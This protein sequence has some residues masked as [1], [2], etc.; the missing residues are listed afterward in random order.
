MKRIYICLALFAFLLSS[1]ENFLDTENLTQK[2]TSNYPESPE[3][4]IDLLTGVYNAVRL[5]EMDEN[6]ACAFITSEVLSDDRF[7]G[8]GPDDMDWAYIEQFKCNNYNLY[9]N[10]WVNAYRGIFRANML[11]ETIGNVKWADESL[12]N[13][14]EG[15]A[16]FLRGYAF[17]YLA[18][19]FG[20]APLTLATAPVNIPRASA[21][22]LF[23]QI[24]SDLKQ[25]INK[26]P[27]TPKVSVLGR[28]SK[29]AAEALMARAF[30][31]Y[32]GYYKK[33]TMPLAGEGG[34][35]VTKSEVI[36]YL[37][38]CIS[39]SGFGLYPSFLNLWPYSNELSK[40]DGYTYSVENN[41]QWAGE[42][43]ANN[44]TLFAFSSA[45]KVNWENVSDCNRLNLYFSIREQNE[46]GIFPF[47][48]GWGFGTVNPKLWE[49]WPAKDLRRKGS[50]IDVNDPKEMP[51]YQ[52][53]ADHQQDESGY[54]Q[55]KYIAV[56]VKRPDGSFVN[57]SKEMFGDAVN[58]DYQINNTQD[59]VIIR[60]A[61]VLLMGAELKEDVSLINQVRARA[62]LT[63]I[64]S[65]S[66]AALRNER[67]WEL[68]FEGIRY[69]DLLRWGIAGEA[70]NS[71]NGTE[72][73][74]DM[75][76]NRI[77]LGDLA[78]RIKET[79]GFMPIPQEEISLSN[80]V[81]QQT[82]GW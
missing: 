71:Q 37:D 63:P 70:L 65:Y 43:G 10:T 8:G 9:R 21:D 18:R 57:Y 45:A 28:T 29:W 81:L 2:D 20:T 7:A 56:N 3:D 33:E 48:K 44:E 74:D 13:N 15:Q 54:W 23:A 61:D 26:M 60:F 69:F 41:L 36:S 58:D 4:A 80:G 46:S 16:Y 22:E 31:F 42:T 51:N 59:L 75:V 17:L 67:R 52:W 78:K 12:R 19:L 53:A 24:A 27:S 49:E 77:E 47:G 50:I 25:A 35:S 40:R 30:L 76:S 14:I 32:T 82:P 39:N 55:K 11:L 73:K 66:T 72:V 6:G 79:G 5:M 62:Q 34:G 38:D 1:C 68:A 64:S